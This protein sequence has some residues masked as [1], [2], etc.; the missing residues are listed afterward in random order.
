MWYPTLKEELDSLK[1]I[2]QSEDEDDPTPDLQ[3]PRTQQ[4]L[5]EVRRFFLA[6]VAAINLPRSLGEIVGHRRDRRAHTDSVGAS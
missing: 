3:A 1:D 4:I 5:E 6:A 2:E